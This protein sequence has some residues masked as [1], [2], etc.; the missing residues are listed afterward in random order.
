MAWNEQYARILEQMKKNSATNTAI[1]GADAKNDE[2]D[3][4]F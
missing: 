3:C 2:P 4:L 1:T